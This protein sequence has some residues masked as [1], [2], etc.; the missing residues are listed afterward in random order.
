MKTSCS[1]ENQIER[2]L[3]VDVSSIPTQIVTVPVVE[4]KVRSKYK[5]M[6]KILTKLFGFKVVYEEYYAKVLHF[7]PRDCPIT[8]DVDGT[9]SLEITDMK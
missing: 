7:D 9:V 4:P 6:Q 1:A 3:G 8:E 5:F 2:T